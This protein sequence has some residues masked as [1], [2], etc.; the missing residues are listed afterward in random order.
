MHQHARGGVSLNR[1][2]HDFPRMN[3]RR[4]NR[5]AEEFLALDHAVSAIEV[6]DAEDFVLQLSEAQDQIVPSGC[7]RSESRAASHFICHA[8]ARGVDDFLGRCLA[9]GAKVM[10]VDQKRIERAHER[11]PS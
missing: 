10:I 5:A 6:D 4:V 8:C 3:A 2:P 9:H 1:F 7:R 11:A